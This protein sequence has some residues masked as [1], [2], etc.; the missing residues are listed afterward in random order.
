MTLPVLLVLTRTKAACEQH[1]RHFTE[2]TKH[3]RELPYNEKTHLGLD[4]T[5]LRGGLQATQ[6]NKQPADSKPY[7]TQ[8]QQ[9]Q[10]R[11]TL[12]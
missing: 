11:L 8:Q 12:A 7:D 9:Q 5:Q 1:K 10:H 3:E 6:T 4:I 2:A